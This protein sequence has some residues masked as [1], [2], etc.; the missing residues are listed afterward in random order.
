MLQQ[1]LREEQRK[2]RD[3]LSQLVEHV[4]H[5]RGAGTET[6]A[7]RMTTAPLKPRRKIKNGFVGL[8]LRRP[9]SEEQ[10]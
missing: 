1:A 4:G 5:P 6:R 7:Y 8:R 9:D 3:R 2:D 10:H